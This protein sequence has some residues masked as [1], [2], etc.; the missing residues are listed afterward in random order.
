MNGLR[1]K[2][3]EFC[4]DRGLFAH[5]N[6]IQ[7]ACSGGS[8]SV[9]MLR[10]LFDTRK[11]FGLELFCTHVD[12][13]LRP[14]SSID[15]RFVE[16]LCSRMEVEFEC[17]KITDLP[18]G[19][20]EDWARTKRRELLA[21]TVAKHKL[22]LTALAH[23]ANDRAET[24]LHNIARGAGLEGAGNM[25]EK[26]GKIVRPL[27]FATKN[28]ILEY[29]G[30]YGQDFVTDETNADT[31]FSRNMIRHEMIAK[32]EKVFPKSAANISRFARMAHED[33]ICLDGIAETKLFSI[34]KN[35]SLDVVAFE[36]QPMAIKRRMIRIL[37]RGVHAP[38]LSAC[39][40]AVEFIENS[41]SGKTFHIGAIGLIKV[42]KKIVNVFFL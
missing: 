38:S 12:H 24:L 32:L 28:E 7:V 25:T 41:E 8:D 42:S 39:E 15:A 4:S 20:L 14:T 30:E 6:R 17:V 29:L 16:G 31:T 1:H 9:A 23:N 34:L 21:Q 33:S 5:G 37:S 27:L 40:N 13:G 26:S 19:N 22:D 2:F 35:N 10:L 36:M 18:E 3:I 11:L